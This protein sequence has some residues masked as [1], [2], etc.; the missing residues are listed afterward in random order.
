MNTEQLENS[1]YA[2]EMAELYNTASALR[3]DSECPMDVSMFDVL[4]QKHSLDA[5]SNPCETLM[6][7][8]GINPATDT[9]SNIVTVS[10]VNVRWIIPEIFRDAIR[11]GLRRAPIY[12]NIIASEQP[13]GGLKITMPFINM[14]DADARYVGEAETIQF[15]GISYGSKEI[16]V[17]KMGRGIKISDEVR[18]FSTLNVVSLFLQDFGVRLGYGLDTLA[19]DVLLNGEQVDGSESAPVVGITTPDTLIYSD[20]LRVWIR[21]SR[22]GKNATTMVGGEDITLKLLSL[23]EYK[24]RQNSGPLY[25]NLDVKTPIPNQASIYVHGSIPANQIVIMDPSSTLLKFNSR[26][27]LVESER[28]ISN[29]TEATYATLTT[30]FAVMFRDSRIVVDDTLNITDHNFPAYMNVDV[31]EQSTI[32]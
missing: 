28:I 11:L 23:P 13:L 7:D 25:A 3:G 10:D 16:K 14:S 2:G 18:Q 31:L 5:K 27:L 4:A 8:L 30:G 1:K 20:L 6:E 26:P 9:I 19:I 17:R 32:K 15:G 22:M 12:P 29:Q 24:F 21:L